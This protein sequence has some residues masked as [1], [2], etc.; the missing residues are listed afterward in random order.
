M[1][2]LCPKTLG[3]STLPF[4]LLQLSQILRFSATLIGKLDSTVVSRLEQHDCKTANE[5]VGLSSK[6]HSWPPIVL[7]SI[8]GQLQLDTETAASH[9]SASEASETRRC[10]KPLIEDQGHAASFSGNEQW[11]T[12]GKACCLFCGLAGETERSAYAGDLTFENRSLKVDGGLVA[13]L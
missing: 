9:V 4:C 6:T 12:I 7:P 13:V 11:K 1:P 2:L 8:S 10:E 5:Y 3:S